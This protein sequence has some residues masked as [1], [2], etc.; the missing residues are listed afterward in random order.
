MAGKKKRKKIDWEA[1]EREIRAGQLSIREIARL[2]GCGESSIRKHKKKYNITPDLSK[3]VAEK[4]RTELVRS[5]VRTND[6][7]TDQAIVDSAAARGVEV[8]K[9]H[10]AKIFYGEAVVEKLFAQL[11][12]VVDNRDEIEGQIEEETKEDVDPKR[13]AMMLRAVSIQANASTA[14]SLSAALKNLVVLGRQAFNI[15]EGDRLRPDG[16]LKEVLDSLDGKTWGLP[17]E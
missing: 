6:P 3:R 15:D 16:G 2:Y 1:I 12:E 14:V 4:V 17:S 8:I 7:K 13:R 10:R 9:S 5:E 11:H